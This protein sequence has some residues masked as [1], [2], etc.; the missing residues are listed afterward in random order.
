MLDFTGVK[1]ITIPEG[2]VKKITRGTTLLWEKPSE[3]SVTLLDYIQFN[4][5]MVFD[6]GIV[7]TENTRIET[8]FTRG[9]SDVAYF[10]GVRNSGNT[11]S[12]TAY[13]SNSGAWRFGNTYKN[14]T[15]QLNTEHT[16]VVDKSGILANGKQLTYGTTIKAFTANAT[17]IIGSSRSTSGA[18]ASA[19][20]VGKVFY[21]R[22]YSRGTLRIDWVPAQR[23][24]RVYG[25]WDNV[26][27][28]F[29]TPV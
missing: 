10:Y 7:C 2:S 16:M 13:L 19:Q 8:K 26:S 9:S 1:S 11:A 3:E 4:K 17:L 21:F 14:Q 20:F 5:D 27:N 12:V 24:D 15:L 22:M 28:T 6:T 25:F 29:I 23:S 18:L